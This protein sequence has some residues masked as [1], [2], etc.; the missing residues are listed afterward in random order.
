MKIEKQAR[1]DLYGGSDY[2]NSV[3][4][5]VA[6]DTDKRDWCERD[7]GLGPNES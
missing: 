2:Q 4:R 3:E 7:E 5:A 1:R 6:R